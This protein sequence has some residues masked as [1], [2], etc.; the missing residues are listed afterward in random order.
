MS[1]M[2]PAFDGRWKAKLERLK[3]FEY[4]FGF[5]LAAGFILALHEYK[6]VPMAVHVFEHQFAFHH[7]IWE[8]TKLMD[9]C[10]KEA[11]YLFVITPF[12][13]VISTNRHFFRVYRKPVKLH[14]LPKMR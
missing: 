10:F 6:L 5:P 4:G 9:G 12:Q 13:T 3:M 14:P 7:Q 8:S 2:G 1:I 11:F